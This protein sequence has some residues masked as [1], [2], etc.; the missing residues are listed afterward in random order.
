MI[1][2][3]EIRPSG[4]VYDPQNRDTEGHVPQGWDITL[5]IEILWVMTLRGEI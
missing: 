1:L 2:R 5:R 4:V 3:V